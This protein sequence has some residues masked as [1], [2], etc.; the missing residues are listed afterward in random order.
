MVG[1]TRHLGA[2]HGCMAGRAPGGY[3]CDGM[4]WYPLQDRRAP[5]AA[6]SGRSPSL[7]R[8]AARKAKRALS[9]RPAQP[10]KKKKKPA[11]TPSMKSKRGA[12]AT[13]P[14]TPAD[15]DYNY[16][17]EQ[18]EFLQSLE[19]ADSASQNAAFFSSL[20]SN[21]PGRTATGLRRKV[22]E[23]MRAELTGC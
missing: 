2:L 19:Q 16:R 15:A 3:R 20:L 21:F 6:R 12:A 10:L 23:R 22:E 9:Q 7:S 4:P 8:D 13:R 5:A 14:K 18:V 1:P 11:D 17:P